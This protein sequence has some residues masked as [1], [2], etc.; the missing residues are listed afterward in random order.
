MKRLRNK[1]ILHFII[2]FFAFLILNVVLRRFFALRGLPPQSWEKIY[3]NLSIFVITSL[4]FATVLTVQKYFNS[5]DDD[6]K[7]K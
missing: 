3:S 5:H 1:I 7:I 4:I 2:S 6:S